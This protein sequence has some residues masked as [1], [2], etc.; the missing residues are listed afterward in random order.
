M[1]KILLFLTI[2]LLGIGVALAQNHGPT[3][4]PDP[5]DDQCGCNCDWWTCLIG[6]CTAPC[7]SAYK[8]VITSNLTRMH[9]YTPVSAW[10]KASVCSADSNTTMVAV[11]TTF[12]AKRTYDKLFLLNLGGKQ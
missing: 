10:K 1:T 9:L 12:S 2:L 8:S 6:N 4:P 7:Q 3:V 11:L 5:G